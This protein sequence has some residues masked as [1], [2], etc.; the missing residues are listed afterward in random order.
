M[1]VCGGVGGRREQEGSSGTQRVRPMR[2]SFPTHTID[3]PPR[4][5][6]AFCVLHPDVGYL[7]SMNFV[8]GFLLVIVGD[9]E[10]CFWTFSA[11]TTQLLQGYYCP[12]M[13]A[14][15]ADFAVFRACL[16]RVSPTLAH[17]L[18]STGF[19]LSFTLPRWFL[20]G[21]LCTLPFEVTVRLWDVLFLSGR[22]AP[23]LL[24]QVGLALVTTRQAE[25]LHCSSFMTFASLM[26]VWTGVATCAHWGRPPI[27]ASPARN[28]VVPY[29]RCRS[30]DLSR[31]S[32]TESRT[33]AS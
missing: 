15:Q 26:Q 23:R 16:A 7:Q 30:V 1:H 28:I 6:Q 24:V 29:S 9:E 31:S 11:L 2:V 33:P 32:E 22:Q 3:R 25:L 5:G 10:T 12:G 4:F 21:F 13:P 18:E 8:C 20:C 27:H 19:D 17:H 14:L